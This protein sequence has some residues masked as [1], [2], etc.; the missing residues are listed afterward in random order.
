[1]IPQRLDNLIDRHRPAR[2]PATAPPPARASGVAL[3]E[4]FVPLAL[5]RILSTRSRARSRNRPV[6]HR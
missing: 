3:I 2:L 6:R 1:M 5:A 4:Q